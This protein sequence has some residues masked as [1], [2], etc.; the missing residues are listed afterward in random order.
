M[1]KPGE[2][3]FFIVDPKEQRGIHCRF[4]MP[5]IIAE[6]HY[7]EKLGFSR[8]LLVYIF[9]CVRSRCWAKLRGNGSWSQAVYY[10]AS[11]VMPRA[12]RDA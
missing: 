6:A 4:G 5:G 12:V 2:Q 8:S 11:I 10:L 1:Y 9:D 7:G 3:S